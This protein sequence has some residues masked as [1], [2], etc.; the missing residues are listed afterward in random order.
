[1]AKLGSQHVSLSFARPQLEKDFFVVGI[2]LQPGSKAIE[3]VFQVS[4]T[5]FGLLEKYF[6]QLGLSVRQEV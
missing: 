5:V 3:S 2:L 4:H 1:V 6:S